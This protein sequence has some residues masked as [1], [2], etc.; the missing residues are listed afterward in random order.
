[1]AD[2]PSWN[3]LI[4][5]DVRG[6]TFTNTI[7]NP[8][9]WTPSSLTPDASASLLQQRPTVFIR[10]RPWSHFPGLIAVSKLPLLPVR[11][12]ANQARPNDLVADDLGGI[13]YTLTGAGQVVYIDPD[14][15]P[16]R[17]REQYRIAEWTHPLAGPKD[18]LCGG[19]GNQEDLGLPDFVPWKDGSGP[20]V[21]RYGFRARER[22]GRHV[23][24][25]SWKRLLCRTQAH[26]DLEPVRRAIEKIEAPERPINCIWGQRSQAS[27]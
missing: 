6:D 23:R 26:L 22:G 10:K 2:R 11:I 8:A 24:G 17:C 12:L 20:A 15:N 3:G 18:S 14:G 19:H 27:T 4:I 7:Q 21:C 25:P 16:T 5:P 13:Y 9:Q 1:M